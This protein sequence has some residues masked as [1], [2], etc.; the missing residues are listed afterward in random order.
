[1]NTPGPSLEFRTPLQRGGPAGVA[2]L[3]YHLANPRLDPIIWRVHGGWDTS[4][5]AA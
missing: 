2:D 4:P 5:E 1:M 3:S